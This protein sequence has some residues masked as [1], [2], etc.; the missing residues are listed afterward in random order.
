MTCLLHKPCAA[1]SAADR[2]KRSSQRSLCRSEDATKVCRVVDNEPLISIIVPVRDGE[3]FIG[4]TLQSALGQTY[5]NTELIIVDDG[6]RDRTRAIVDQWAERDPRVRVLTQPNRGVAA[7]RNRALAAA[8][9]QFIAPLDADDLWD[10]SKIERQMRRMIEAGD[11]TGMVYCWWVSI[12]ADG[13][14]LDCSPQW[15]FEGAGGDIMLQVNYTGNGS[16]PLY[17]RRCLEEIGGYD[18][19]LSGTSEGCDDWDIA[20]KVTERWSVAV[21]PAALV[22]Y[23]KHPNTVSSRPDRMWQSY[24]QVMAGVRRRR[25][26]LAAQLLRRSQ[27]QFG[28]YLAGTAYRAGEYRKAIA[29][30][31]PALRSNL[32]LQVLPSVGW[33]FLKNWL[34]RGQPGSRTII[35]PGEHF[36][37]WPMPQPPIPYER[38]YQRRF[39]QSHGG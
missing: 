11:E 27:H 8:R 34:S 3:A 13:S 5:R 19:K 26:D 25:P 15:R 14:L 28:L 35:R 1:R 37:Q 38:I 16:V 29:L 17:R 10:P 32:A 7:A 30:G 12:G 2:V 18:E 24:A 9:G 20:L 23:R 31:W 21:A 4:D 6:S 33:M 36:S 22:A 39:K